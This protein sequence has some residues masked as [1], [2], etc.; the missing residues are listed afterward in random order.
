M[1]IFDVPMPKRGRNPRRPPGIRP[2]FHVGQ[3][4]IFRTGNFVYNA[5][6][7]NPRSGKDYV[8]I[9][10]PGHRLRNNDNIELKTITAT[11]HP[12]DLTPIEKP[13]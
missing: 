13:P 9:E 4:V 5:I 6:V 12:M 3:E 10:Y 1:S 11:V 8:T 2:T 7:I